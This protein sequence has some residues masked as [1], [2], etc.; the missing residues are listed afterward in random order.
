[1]NQDLEK[2]NN[3]NIQRNI[4]VD[5]DDNNSSATTPTT[6]VTIVKTYNMVDKSK[7]LE[8]KNR[9]ENYAVTSTKSSHWSSASL[10]SIVSSTSTNCSYSGADIGDRED[11]KSTQSNRDSINKTLNSISNQ[12]LSPN[13][14]Y[15]NL[16]SDQHNQKQQQNLYG[17]QLLLLSN[18]LQPVN[19]LAKAQQSYQTTGPGKNIRGSKEKI[20]YLRERKA[21]KTIGIVVLGDCLLIKNFF[22][23]FCFYSTIN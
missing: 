12:Q 10:C 5:A 9:L 3:N 15:S 14:Y 19:L 16:N 17:H 6:L 23:I 22:N 1:M 8:K 7:L 2:N 21:L 11:L 20:V 18:R 13:H 4:S